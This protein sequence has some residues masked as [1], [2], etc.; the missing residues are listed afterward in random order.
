[1]G[2]T[3]PP[4]LATD[5]EGVLSHTLIPQDAMVGTEVAR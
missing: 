2:G 5:V 3:V 1:V 4:A